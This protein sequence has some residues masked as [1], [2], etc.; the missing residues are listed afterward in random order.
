MAKKPNAP[1][2]PKEPGHDAA[3]HMWATRMGDKDTGWTV[4]LDA[5]LRKL[6]SVIDQLPAVPRT[7]EPPPPPPTYPPK[8]LP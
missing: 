2:S 4:Q 3:L 8:P 6:T 7:I 1:T 5:W